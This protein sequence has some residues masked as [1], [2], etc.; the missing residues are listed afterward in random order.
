M[1]SLAKFIT[2][3]VTAFCVHLSE[4]TTGNLQNL[5]H[6]Q[7][8]R[9]YSYSFTTFFFFISLLCDNGKKTLEANTKYAFSPGKPKIVKL[10]TS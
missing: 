4:Y 2:N 3:S 10:L 1:I 5:Q 7:T 9:T 6:K 8:R